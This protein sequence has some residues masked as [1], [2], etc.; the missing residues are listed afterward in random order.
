MRG[1]RVG[2]TRTKPPAISR[3]RSKGYGWG[4]GLPRFYWLGEIVKVK[5]FA[6]AVWLTRRG[7]QAGDPSLR[8]KSGYAQ[9]DTTMLKSGY[10]Q[11]DT[12]MLKSGCA[13]DDT[14]GE[15]ANCSTA[16]LCCGGWR[17]IRRGFES[18]N[19]VCS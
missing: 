9:D 13:Q 8:L 1:A 7:G 4:K 10:A 3:G 18:C 11:D 2:W 14:T 12:T 17:S 15:K 5:D 19:S 16:P 6:V